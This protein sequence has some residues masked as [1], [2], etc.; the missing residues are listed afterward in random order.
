MYINKRKMNRRKNIR[1]IKS[2]EKKKTKIIKSIKDK[3]S[4]WDGIIEDFKITN[5]SFLRM[6]RDDFYN[7]EWNYG[8]YK[9][10][11]ENKDTKWE[12]EKRTYRY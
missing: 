9:L 3:R 5:K 8:I 12:Q 7:S 1:K 11:Y 4:T 10:L 6:N 2:I